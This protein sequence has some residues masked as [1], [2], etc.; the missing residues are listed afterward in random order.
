MRVFLNAGSRSFGESVWR[1]LPEEVHDVKIVN[2]DNAGLAEVVAIMESGS[3]TPH[4]MVLYDVL[5]S[6]RT[7]TFPLPSGY[8]RYVTMC[9]IDGDGDQDAC[10]ALLGSGAL[11]DAIVVVQ[12]TDHG[13]F[14]HVTVLTNENAGRRYAG[15]IVSG[16][17]NGDG[18]FDL[19]VGVPY[20]NHEIVIFYNETPQGN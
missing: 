11:A 7:E 15:S 10:I 2:A 12:N 4:L 17:F 16:D 9:D 1:T 19:A 14:E 13:K 18:A 5:G 6:M 20:D 3:S 8:P